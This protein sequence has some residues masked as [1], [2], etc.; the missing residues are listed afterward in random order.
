MS[1]LETVRAAIL[2]ALRGVPDVGRVH[3]RPRYAS[4]DQAW[5]AHY[6]WPEGAAKPQI[7]GWFVRRVATREHAPA[8]GRRVVDHRWL[9]T[10]LMSLVDDAATEIA[11]DDL[12]ERVRAAFLADDTLGGA[13]FGT[14]EDL[15]SSGAAGVQV[16][17]SETVMFAGVLC[18]RVQ[19]TLVTRH[20]E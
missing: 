13:V 10:G 12:V 20:L 7:R 4:N 11:L 14:F 2:D 8:V 18:H 19:L 5:R 16:A 9:I 6:A 17:D 1:R 3:D 15:G